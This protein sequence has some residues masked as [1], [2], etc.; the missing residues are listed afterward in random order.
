MK[1]LDVLVI[2]FVPFILYAITIINIIY[3]SVVGKAPLAYYLHSHSVIYATCFFLIS[4]ANKRYHC[5]Y[6]RAMYLYLI[7]IPII[8]YLEAK[9]HIF[10]TNQSKSIFI[11]I[12]SIIVAAITAYLAIKHFVTISKRKLKNGSNQ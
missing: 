2:R 4:L 7:A 11:V 1:G 3:C 6:N 10:P 9:Y 12:S 5:V 8:N